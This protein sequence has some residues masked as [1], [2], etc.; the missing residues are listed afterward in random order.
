MADKGQEAR[1]RARRA[2]GGSVGRRIVN[3]IRETVL[4]ILIALV[5]ATLIKTFLAQMFVIPS[6][7]MQQTLELQDRVMVVKVTSYQRGDIVVFED[8][9]GWLPPEAPSSTPKKILEF[10][11]LLPASGNQYLIKRLIGLPGDHVV[12]CSTSGR[13]SVNGQ[14]LDESSYLYRNPDGSTVKPSEIL[15]DVTVPKGHIFVLG[16]HRNASA[17][18]RYHLCDTTRGSKGASAFPAVSSIQGPAKLNVF[19]FNRWRTFSVPAVYSAVPA[20]AGDPPAVAVVSG[21]G[22]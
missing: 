12:C 20:A 14:E 8:N 15:F 22:C 19:P 16:D 11:G 10:I 2:Q 6:T 7:S 17:D 1:G 9:L 4:V 18:S 13:V 5:I 21:G 3:G